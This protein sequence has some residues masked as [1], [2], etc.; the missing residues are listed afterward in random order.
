MSAG[1]LILTDCLSV[2][3]VSVDARDSQRS[4]LHGAAVTNR[5]GSQVEGKAGQRSSVRG[6]SIVIHSTSRGA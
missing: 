3:H 4:P 1:E 2:V 6:V 5:G